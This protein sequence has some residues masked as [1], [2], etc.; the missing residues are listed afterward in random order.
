LARPDQEREDPGAANVVLPNGGRL[1][2]DHAHPEYSSPEVTGPRD[3]VVFDKAGERVMLESVRRLSATSA[4]P[5]VVLY[6]NNVDGKGATY[7][8]HENYLVDRAVPFD[9]LVDWLTP[10]LV[11][12]QVFCGAGRVGLGQRGEEAG[13]QLSQRADYV[14]AEVGLE[15]TL[16]RPIINTRDE[17]HCDA[18]RWRRLH[19]ILGDAT[20][21]ETTTYVRA[22]TTSAVLWLAEQAHRQ[23]QRPARI[24]ALR[25]ADPVQAVQQVSRDLS[26]SVPLLLAD[27]RSLTA[28][29]I[30][31]VYLEAVAEAVGT[32]ADEETRDVLGRWERLLDGLAEDPMTCA[33]D[34]E[35]VAKL[36]LL[37]ALRRREALGWDHPKL[38]AV[39]LQWSDVRPERGLYHRLVAAGAV[40][41]LVG[42]D[43]VERA[44]THPPHDTR[45][46]FRGEVVRRYPENVAA[47]S[48]D[49]VVFDAPH[50]P[51]LQRVP[52]R[53]PLRGTKAHVGDLLDGAPDV[54]TLLA[55][56]G[57]RTTDR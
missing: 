51:T 4:L 23:G 6:K 47:A 14:E 26:V 25:L 57:V 18:A 39:D 10:F 45:A 27:G 50:Q 15:T 24:D 1:Y 7:G 41:T 43:E 31:R 13:F 21:L 5:D 33:R 28:L 22:G 54:E 11:T 52:T 35:W 20:L 46:Y 29:Q 34:V 40:A 37:D 38:Q 17:P 12:R 2:V 48:W 32:D 53:D 8:T 56:L 55:G 3:L 49:S 16:R 19:V 30:Q 42:Q 9:D 36:R 44:V